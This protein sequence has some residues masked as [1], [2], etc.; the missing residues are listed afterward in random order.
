MN[1]LFTG[2]RYLNLDFKASNE[3]VSL[4]CCFINGQLRIGK[5]Q[6]AKGKG[7]RR[8]KTAYLPLSEN[9][10]ILAGQRVT[11]NRRPETKQT[12]HLRT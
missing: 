4:T 10:G 7:P 3:W 5:G 2:R 12:Q 11:G 9:E 6:R 1:R 8:G